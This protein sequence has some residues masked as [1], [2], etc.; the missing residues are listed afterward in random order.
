MS[1][2]FAS[3][4]GLSETLLALIPDIPEAQRQVALYLLDH[5]AQVP[6]MSATELARAA[7]TSQS[8]VTRF[9]ARLGFGNYAEFTQALQQVLLHEIEESIPL[10]RFTRVKGP[11]SLLQ[12]INAEATNLQSLTQVVGS[13]TF[14]RCASQIAQARKIY[15]IALGAAKSL[16]VHMHLYLSRLREGVEL[17][18]DSGVDELVH[19]MHSTPQDYAFFPLVPRHPREAERLGKA[20][21]DRGVP[22]GLA[23]DR[24]GVVVAPFASEILLTPV[25]NGPTTALPASLLMLVS[26]LVDAVALRNPERTQLTLSNFEELAQQTQVFAQGGRDNRA[27][28]KAKLE[29][30]VPPSPTRKGRRKPQ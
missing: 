4:S 1:I 22:I 12:L 21:H 25:L 7:Q 15:L 30:F 27:D 29:P 6:M 5:F 13:E 16:G 26:L 20:L 8:S 28:W 9:A 10:E 2:A 18:T 3:R 11:D 14:E 23:T 19:L 24:S 17:I